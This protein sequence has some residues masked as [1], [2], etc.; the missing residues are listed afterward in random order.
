MTKK[1][2][3]D[4][5]AELYKLLE[6]LTSEERT[7]VI[8]GTL[9]LLGESSKVIDDASLGGTGGARQ[10][11][12]PKGAG[13]YFD[14]KM[15][16]TKIEEMA[17]AARFYETAK[18]GSALRKEDFEAIF[19]DARRNFD[20]HNF[21]RDM[22]NARIAGLFNKGGTAKTGYTLSY[23]GQNYVDSLPDRTAVKALRR[24]T[25]VSSKKSKTAKSKAT[26]K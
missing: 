24:P 2:V 25:R 19:K 1:S 7:R 26:H 5:S 23:Y 17:T 14:T 13:A 4:S 11:V 21:T 8:L 10:S 15:A 20:S 3:A 16:Q 22:T 6:P 18:G 12:S 9:T